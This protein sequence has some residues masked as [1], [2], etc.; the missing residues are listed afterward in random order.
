MASRRGAFHQFEQLLKRF[1]VDSP[2][3]KQQLKRAYLKKVKLWHPDVSSSPQAKKKFLELQ[4]DY[5]N[6]EKFFANRQFLIEWE[7]YKSGSRTTSSLDFEDH[8][9]PHY[10]PQQRHGSPFRRAD[11]TESAGPEGNE[12]YYYYHSGPFT[13]PESRNLDDD[14]FEQYRKYYEERLRKNPEPNHFTYADWRHY[15]G[16]FPFLLSPQLF[17]FLSLLFPLA[18]LSSARNRRDSQK[19]TE[20]DNKLWVISREIKSHLWEEL[21]SSNLSNCPLS[22]PNSF[23]LLSID[24]N[25]DVLSTKSSPNRREDLTIG[26]SSPAEPEQEVQVEPPKST[27]GLPTEKPRRRK[28]DFWDGSEEGLYKHVEASSTGGRHLMEEVKK[29]ARKNKTGWVNFCSIHTHIWC[30]ATTSRSLLSH[31]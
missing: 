7:Q 12:K 18:L 5:H 11:G 16:P 30:R 13:R 31:A 8:T 23:V 26:L 25:R 22:C 9:Q 19:Y 21:K 10:Q 17:L 29:E 3:N 6:L 14:P 15:R 20:A 1:E 28:Q 27:D 4:D 2:V 24:S